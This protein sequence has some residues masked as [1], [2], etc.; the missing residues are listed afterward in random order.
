MVS[1]FLNQMAHSIFLMPIDRRTRSADED[2]LKVKTIIDYTG[3]PI[4]IALT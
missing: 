3:F 4:P 1:Q 2:I